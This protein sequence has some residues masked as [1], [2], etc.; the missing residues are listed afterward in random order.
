MAT[1]SAKPKAPPP[2]PPAACSISK[3]FISAKLVH[4]SQIAILFDSCNAASFFFVL[5]IVLFRVI[6]EPNRRCGVLLRLSRSE[7]CLLRVK[8]RNA[9]SLL[10]KGVCKSWEFKSLFQVPPLQQ[11]LYDLVHVAAGDLLRAEIASGSENGKRARAYMDKGQL[12]PDEI[13]VMVGKLYSCWL[14]VM[15]LVILCC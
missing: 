9:S 1:A 8:E 11:Y 4:S 6:L 7:L 15:L 5:S 13:V 12:V 14:I 2:P 10:R 3:P